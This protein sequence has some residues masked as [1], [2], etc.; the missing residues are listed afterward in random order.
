VFKP[1]EPDLKPSEGAAEPTDK[2]A[3][4][5]MDALNHALIEEMERDPGVVIF[6]Q[7]VARGKG[8]VFG[9]TR[10][11][12]DRFT[13]NR[14]FNTP[15]AESTIIALATGLS[16]A[17]RGDPICRLCLDRDEPTLQ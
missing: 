3:I 6:G 4:V 11:L 16:F 9:I 15:L 12:T 10:T 5:L 14:C 17:C 2:E 1:Y 13:E 7:D 8:G